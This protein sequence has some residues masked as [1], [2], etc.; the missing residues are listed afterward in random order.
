[1]RFYFAYGSNMAP[2]AMARRCP[3]AELMGAAVL[4]H[5]RFAIIRSGHGT[6]L[7]KPGADVHGVLWHIG[8]RDEAA[9]D[10]YEEVARGLYRRERRLVL[11]HGRR[12]LALIYVAAPKSRGQPRPAYIQAI[13]ASARRFGFPA[14]YIAALSAIA[15]TSA[16]EWPA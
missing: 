10:R 13:I 5:H 8:A 3:H 12:I 16:G 6:V 9:L 2:L 4:P 15:R 1:M 11:F 14:S 7:R